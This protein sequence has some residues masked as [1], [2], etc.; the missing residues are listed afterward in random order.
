M[1]D[2]SRLL[3][4][5]PVPA[6]R[7]SNTCADHLPHAFS[8]PHIFFNDRDPDGLRGFYHLVQD[9][10]AFVLS[11]ISLHFKIQPIQKV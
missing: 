4:A 10:K 5:A 2:L 8:L 9:L 6:Y 1:S 7:F 3:D 11:L